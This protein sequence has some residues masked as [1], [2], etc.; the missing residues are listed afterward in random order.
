MAKGRVLRVYLQEGLRRRAALGRHN[1]FAI[2]RRS[3]EAEGFRVEYRASS[4]AERE[5]AQGRGGY[6]LY[7]MEEPN[8]PRALTLWRAYMYPFWRFERTNR[9]GGWRLGLERFDPDMADPGPARRFFDD[10]RRRL[11]P[12]DLSPP[13]PGYVYMPLQ[14][15]LLRHRSFQTMSPLEMIQQTLEAEPA[16]RILLSLHPRESYGP[17]ERTA[18]DTVLTNPRVIEVQGEMHAL[19]AGCDYVVTQNSSVSFHGL[20]H[21]KPAVL[22]AETDF[23]HLHQEVERTGVEEA[24]RRV[25]EPLRH[26]DR[27]LYWYLQMGCINGGRRDAGERILGQCRA[28]GWKI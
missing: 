8:H 14:G 27:Y 26:A 28:L 23:H 16:R 3:F 1:F 19:L 11:I 25:Q 18:L 2:L 21:E 6:T 20:F 4:P 9:R 13:E 22:F 10:W 24:F 5:A 17:K 12:A 7:H 15:R